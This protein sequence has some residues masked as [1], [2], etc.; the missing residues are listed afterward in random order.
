[1]SRVVLAS[2]SP[3]RRA[4]LEQL[5]VEFDGRVPDV[6][7]LEPGPPH[8]VALEN[9]FRK[10]RA[11]AARA[12]PRRARRSGVDTLVASAAR[13]YGKPADEAQAR[14]MLRALAGRRHTVVSGVCADRGRRARGRRR[15][16]PR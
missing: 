12:M 13:L 8:E 11:V 10:A 4:I 15:R 14:A 1:M 9:A 16:A 2:R 5:G 3:Q 6:E 7:E